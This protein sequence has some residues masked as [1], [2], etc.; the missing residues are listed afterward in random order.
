MP[1]VHPGIVAHP[2]YV[3][4]D[5]NPVALPDPDLPSSPDHS[6][7]SSFSDTTLPLPSAIQSYVDRLAELSPSPSIRNVAVIDLL[8]A[9]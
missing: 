2:E 4:G 8:D 3:P 1:V 9:C 6:V 7:A 5:D